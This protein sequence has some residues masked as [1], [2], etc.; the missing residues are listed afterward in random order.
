M[1]RSLTEHSVTYT[2]S[3]SATRSFAGKLGMA[4]RWH[5]HEKK[6]TKLIRIYQDDYDNANRFLSLDGSCDSMAS[7]FHRASSAYIGSSPLSRHP[8]SKNH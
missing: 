8:S 5:G 7:F 4:S 6:K 1:P 2:H 3:L